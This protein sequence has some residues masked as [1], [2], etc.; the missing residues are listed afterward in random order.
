MRVVL[1]NPGRGSGSYTV[2]PSVGLGTIA[3]VLRNAGH[4]VT[5]FDANRDRLDDRE[6]AARVRAFNADLIGVTCF[7]P[8][9]SS[10]ERTAAFLRLA[11]PNIIIV[12]GGPHPTFE[13]EA[14]L[15]EI[16]AA[17]YVIAGEGETAMQL[18]CDAIEQGKA[19]ADVPNLY[20][21]DGKTVIPPVKRCVEEI[22]ALP[23]P[24]WD[25]LAPETYPT[26]PNG[27]FSRSNKVAPVIAT[28]GC[29][30]PCTFCGASRSMGKKLR[31]RTAA[32]LIEEIRLL[33]DRHGIREIHF[34]DDNFTFDADLV[35]ELCETLLAEGPKIHWA[36]PN[37]VRIDR[38]D[39]ELAVLME[40]AGC[41]SM[42][43]GIEFGT[44]RILEKVRKNITVEQIER[45]IRMIKEKTDIRLTGFFILGHPDETEADIRRT[46]EMSL[47][48][49]LDRANFFNFTPFPGSDLYEELKAQGALAGLRYED[50]YIHSI[51]YHP[52]AISA[53]SMK[54][55]Q[56]NAHLRFY[57]R[58]R[59]L[60]GL[61]REMRTMAQF[62]TVLV[63]AA[64]LLVGR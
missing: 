56:R 58:P 27:I 9:L 5:V 46:V 13:P 31:A 2:I 20:F 22:A 51:A 16:P 36:C 14:T 57:L 34:M 42:A 54:R 55:L 35:R 10:V 7:T 11:L 53:E 29:P 50:L 40:R 30:F 6:I 24:A 32:S 17:D 47:R 59:I 26:A 62:R 45:Q 38:I 49:P 25:L 43:L 41:Y 3:A 15:N 4:A 8:F 21:R 61:L 48:L 52:P 18:L 44:D 1:L 37:G 60:L 28:R 23:I 33:Y 12:L 64:H 63:R 19:V 39:E